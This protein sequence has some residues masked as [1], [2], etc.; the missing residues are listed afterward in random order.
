MIDATD[1]KKELDQR[2][3]KKSD[4]K[5]YETTW[6]DKEVR[7]Q[8]SAVGPKVKDDQRWGRRPEDELRRLQ[9]INDNSPRRFLSDFD[10]R[11]ELAEERR[12]IASNPEGFLRRRAGEQLDRATLR[13][14]WD[15][16]ERRQIR[17]R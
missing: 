15:A 3:L 10:A 8:L 14:T 6:R 7:G 5:L 13:E 12:E 4:Q 11:R 2:R 17:R 9:R 1:R 16:V